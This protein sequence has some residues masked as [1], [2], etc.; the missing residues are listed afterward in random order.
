M[1]HFVKLKFNKV[2]YTNQ[3]HGLI[4]TFCPII[5][6]QRARYNKAICMHC[7]PMMIEIIYGNR[8]EQ[9]FA[10]ETFCMFLLRWLTRVYLRLDSARYHR[11]PNVRINGVFTNDASSPKKKGNHFGAWKALNHFGISSNSFKIHSNMCYPRAKKRMTK[12]LF[13]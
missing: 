9:K 10:N 4:W 11:L 1:K 7:R 5:G 8:N 6:P 13:K 12:K 3:G 2:R